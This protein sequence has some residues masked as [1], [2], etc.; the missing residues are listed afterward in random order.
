MYSSVTVWNTIWN[1]LLSLNGNANSLWNIDLA[2][3][4][5]NSTKYWMCTAFFLRFWTVVLFLGYMQY[6]LTNILI[7][8]HARF[9]IQRYVSGLVFWRLNSFLY[10]KEENLKLLVC[11]AQDNGI[12][13]M[14]NVSLKIHHNRVFL[15]GCKCNFPIWN[16]LTEN[17]RDGDSRSIWQQPSKGFHL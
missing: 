12:I 17:E 4:G 6:L 11:L 1:Y 13:W 10:V 9:Y 2:S 14:W 3:C 15:F 7:N 8:L 16:A 5:C